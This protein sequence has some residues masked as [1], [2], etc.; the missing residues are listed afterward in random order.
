MD[1]RKRVSMSVPS[2]KTE[3]KTTNGGILVVHNNNL[4]KKIKKT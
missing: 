1:I 3:I 4:E 2:A